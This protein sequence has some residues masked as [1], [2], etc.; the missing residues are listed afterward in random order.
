MNIIKQF[1]FKE[2]KFT[3]RDIDNE[4][5]VVMDTETTGL[6]SHLQDKIISVAAVKTSSTELNYETYDQ[7]VDPQRSIPSSSTKFHGITESDVRGM[8]TLK[9]CEP[10]ITKFFG[11]HTIVGHNVA[12]DLTFLKDGLKGTEIIQTIKQNPVLDTLLLSGVLFPNFESHELSFLCQ[13]F[14][15]P[16]KNRHT[17]LGDVMMTAELL[18]IL[19]QEAKKMKA[20]KTVADLIY[21]TRQAKHYRKLQKESFEIH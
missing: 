9:E 18:F 16:E 2:F 17:A 7:L 20:V 4:T 11:S 19:I 1:F 13:K 8:P 6:N 3:N 15:I 14:K 21:I 5:F 12:F 10:K